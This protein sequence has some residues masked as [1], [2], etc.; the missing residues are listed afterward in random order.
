MCRG[1]EHLSTWKK[2]DK[3]KEK[4]TE[5]GWIMDSFYHINHIVSLKYINLQLI[6]ENAWLYHL[7]F[8]YLSMRKDDFKGVKSVCNDILYN[9]GEKTFG[10]RDSNEV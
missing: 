3:V 4:I 8:V 10:K 7:L 5:I 9:S 1:N 2:Y 6:A